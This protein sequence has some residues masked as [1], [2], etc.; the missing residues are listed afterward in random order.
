MMPP[1]RNPI[2]AVTHPDPYP[3][4]ANLVANRPIYRDETAGFWVA[5]SAATV[6]AILTSDLGRVRPPMEPV[7]TMLLDSP[8]ADVFRHLVRMNDGQK[9]D[10]MK[11]AVSRALRTVGADQ[12]VEQSNIWAR[13]L[14]DEMKPE[15]HPGCLTD[16]TFHL[17]AY[18][19]AS[20]LG[21]PQE[22]LRQTALWMSD[23]VGCLAPTSSPEQLE[24]GKRAA[25]H[26]LDMLHSM[27]GT[28]TT[29]LTS[30]LLNVLVYEAGLAECT[31]KDV[32]V[33]NG[34]GFLSQ[35]Y[36]ATAGLIGN[37]LLTLARQQD[38]YALVLANP[39][40]L[41]PVIQEVLRYD[42][43]VQ[44]TRR[45]LAGSGTV[46]GE[47]M[48]EGDVV[49]VV[50]AAAN[51][52]PAANADP[53]RFDMFRQSRRLFTFGTGV[54]E[55]P[56]EDVAAIIARAGVEQLLLSGVNVLHLTEKVK[57]RSSGNVRVPLFEGAEL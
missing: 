27:L 30:H 24:Q 48:Q 9:H 4:Y 53:T 18:V 2:D 8:A 46:A 54:H 5:S 20:L 21:I 36:E 1:P 22:K 28:Q 57:Y 52:D 56:G 45:Y 33:A 23:F 42:P 25:S 15:A 13:L 16:F 31:D 37:T 49:L 3:Y 41:R 19:V 35:T 32:V 39:D 44:N 10:S 29:R 47:Q 38:V 51:R 12:I 55:C 40:L 7:P 11:G 14:A 17:P 50:L 43:S 6:T 26:L 34:I